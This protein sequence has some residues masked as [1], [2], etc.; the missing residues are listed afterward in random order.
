[1]DKKIAHIKKS[2]KN[3]SFECN[4]EPEQAV[5][6]I[7]DTV[8][9]ILESYPANTL[10]DIGCGKGSLARLLKEKFGTAVYVTELKSDYV[11]EAIPYIAEVDLDN[12][13]L[14]YEDIYFDIITF[15]EVI[16]HLKNP[17]FAM[18][19]ISRV[20]K[21]DGVLILSTPNI[22]NIRSKW[23]FLFN[24]IIH[25]FESE[26]HRN[27]LEHLH[28]FSLI[29]LKRL[30]NENDFQIE[31]I[32]YLGPL[33]PS[34]SWSFYLEN[35]RNKSRAFWKNFLGFIKFKIK[36]CISVLISLMLYKS[37]A[38]NNQ[39]FCQTCLIVAIKK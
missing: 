5:P 23:H 16:E 30:L 4:L 31:N 10:L 28:P 36:Y 8:L 34:Y 24:N 1:M 19:E 3:F 15:I 11:T 29:E 39:T 26:I 32:F 9:K 27:P 20:L 13:V 33:Y 25:G 17:W 7:H 18:A 35:N 2:S 22:H 6:G 37:L 21:K 12:D 38:L 14:P